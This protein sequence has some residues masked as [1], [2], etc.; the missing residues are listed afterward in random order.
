VS[1]Q[2]TYVYS[3]IHRPEIVSSG[4][5]RLAL[6]HST[7]VVDAMETLPM[8]RLQ[9]FLQ[10]LLQSVYT[11]HLHILADMMYTKHSMSAQRYQHWLLDMFYTYQRL[12]DDVLLP[13]QRKITCPKRLQSLVQRMDVVAW[14][15]ASRYYMSR[16]FKG[17]LATLFDTAPY[18]VDNETDHSPTYSTTLSEE[19]PCRYSEKVAFIVDYVQRALDSVSDKIVICSQFEDM[20]D[21]LCLALKPHLRSFQM[22]TILDRHDTAA[23]LGAMH[24]MDHDPTARVALVTARTGT[25]HFA[26]VNHL[27]LVDLCLPTL[28]LDRQASAEKKLIGCL[29]HRVPTLNVV[30]FMVRRS[31]DDHMV[32]MKKHGLGHRTTKKVKSK[33]Q[34]I[35]DL[36]SILLSFHCDE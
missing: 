28:S 29:G 26:L 20:L 33:S 3:V 1:I 15:T 27:I 6:P 24:R 21:R 22:V 18:Y 19:T 31:I 9:S 34:Y 17:Y 13:L 11:P 4:L 14:T 25:L 12:A 8:T 2:Y 5:P 35:R 36:E 30:R 32:Q 7:T 23:R 10:P 16:P